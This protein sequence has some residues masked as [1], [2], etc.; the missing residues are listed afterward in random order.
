VGVGGFGLSRCLVCACFRFL[1]RFVAA[2]ALQDTFVVDA[3]VLV[4]RL[5]LFCFVF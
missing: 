3:L 1:V 5:P 4:L 2:S